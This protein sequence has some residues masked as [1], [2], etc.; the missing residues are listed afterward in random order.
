MDRTK[1]PILWTTAAAVVVLAAVGLYLFQ[2]WRL[3]TSNRVDE[4]APVATD[5]RQVATEPLATGS[6]VS[7]EHETSGSVE[8]Q[9][10]T[11][12]KANLRLTDLRTSDGPALHV[13]LSDQP[14]EQD[15]GGNLDDGD[16]LDLGDLKGNEGNQNYAIPAGTDLDRFSTVT[17][18][19][20]RFSV[21]FGAAELRQST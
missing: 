20:E 2:P 19:C 13:W 8:V 7:H 5:Q 10:L 9:P 3:F 18:W 21:S 14:V 16:H 12:G 11:D 1:R 6:F 15:G 17:I 4:S